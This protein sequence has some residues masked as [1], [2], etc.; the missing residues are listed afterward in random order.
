MLI[1]AGLTCMGSWIKLGSVDPDRFWVGFLGQIV[2]SFGQVFIL[3]LPSGV[4]AVW[5]PLHQQ[6]TAAGIGVFGN[7]VSFIH[8]LINLY[9]ARTVN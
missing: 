8:L 3:S 2:L 4:A 7:Q 9:E 5:F 1:G 6:A